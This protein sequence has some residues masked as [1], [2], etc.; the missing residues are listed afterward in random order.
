MIGEML[1]DEVRSGSGRLP[2]IARKF[3]KALLPIVYPIMK[4]KCLVAFY[5][6]V[7]WQRAYS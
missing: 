6:S 5:L 2:P 1:G 3:E 7:P 4:P